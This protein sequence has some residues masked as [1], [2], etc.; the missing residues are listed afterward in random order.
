MRKQGLI[1]AEVEVEVPFHD[2]DLATVVWHGHYLKYFENARWALMDRIGFGLDAM[3]AS[4]FGWLV[5]AL[6]VDYLRVSR[7]GDRLRVRASLVDWE[8]RLTVNYLVT[9]T[10]S[11]E[12]IA[13]GQTVQA[14][15]EAA[16]GLLQFTTPPVLLERVQGLLEEIEKTGSGS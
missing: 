13:R 15:V 1:S 8:N 10:A 12:R 11:G 4:G 2:V 3:I 5:V 6:Q 16:T 7:Y 9:E 14:A